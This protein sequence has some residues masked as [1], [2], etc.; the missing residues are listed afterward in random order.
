[1]NGYRYRKGKSLEI[2]DRPLQNWIVL[3]RHTRLTV[4]I[5]TLRIHGYHG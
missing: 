5:K 4:A 2:M 3:V 1:M